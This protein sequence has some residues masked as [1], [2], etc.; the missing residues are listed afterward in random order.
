MRMKQL[1]KREIGEMKMKMRYL[2]K[3]NKK[4]DFQTGEIIPL[5]WNEAQCEV[6]SINVR[7]TIQV[8]MYIYIQ[9]HKTCTYIQLSILRYSIY[10]LQQNETE[11]IL[12]EKWA[13]QGTFCFFPIFLLHSFIIIPKN[14][15]PTL[16]KKE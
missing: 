6:F 3:R 8:C 11:D 10:I 9:I 13:E 5:C 15:V 12:Q 2:E 16:A 4:S 7:F 1:G 14:A